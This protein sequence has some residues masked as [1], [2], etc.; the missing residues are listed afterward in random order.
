[1]FTSGIIFII[2]SLAFNA[3]GTWPLV[4]LM[5]SPQVVIQHHVQHTIGTVTMN[6]A[7]TIVCFD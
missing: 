3:S 6:A 5:Q 2:N 4:V 1:V 7:S